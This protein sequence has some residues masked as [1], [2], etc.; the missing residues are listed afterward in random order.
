MYLDPIGL[1][2]SFMNFKANF[3]RCKEQEWVFRCFSML[4]Y[5]RSWRNPALSVCAQAAWV[6]LWYRPLYLVQFLA[7]MG[8]VVMTYKALTKPPLQLFLTDPT[9]FA[10]V[11]PD[12]SLELSD[13]EVCAA[14]P[15]SARAAPPPPPCVVRVPSSSAF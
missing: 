10:P 4:P 3:T 6:A 1:E 2:F 14:R 8:T 12:G 13:D 11:N 15:P 9:L 5:V 7:F